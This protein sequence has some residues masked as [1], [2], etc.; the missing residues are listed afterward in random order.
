MFF[1]LELPAGLDAMALLPEAV[2]AG[3][4]FVPG[5]PFFAAAP[6][7]NSLRLSFVTVPAAQIEAGVAA[8]AHVLR[9][10]EARL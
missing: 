9:A 2:A 3:M 1:W 6:R 10:A 5:A 4:A 7:R 8:L